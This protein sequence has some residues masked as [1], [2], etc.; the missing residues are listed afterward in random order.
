MDDVREEREQHLFLACLEIDA[1]KRDVYLI[2]ASRGNIELQRRLQRLL[3]AHARSQEMDFTPLAGSRI[4]ELATATV[5]PYRI[6]RTLGQGGMGTVYEAE[7]LTPVRR[8]VALKIVKLGMDTK[9][10]V[11]R[12]TTE[13]QALAAMD[14]PYIA[15]IFDA[16]QTSEGRPFFAMEMVQG[17]P[18]LEYCDTQ[19]LSV[20]SRIELMTLVCEAVQH[21]HQKGVVHRDLKPSNVLVASG[22]PKIIDFGIAKA[23]GLDLPERVTDYT[24]ADQA[25]GTPAYMSPEQAGFGRTDVDTRSDVYSLG[26]LLYELLAGCL[27][28]DPAEVGYPTFL[29]LL[30]TGELKTIRPSLRLAVPSEAVQAASVRSATPVNLRKQIQGDL[31]WIVMKSLEVDRRRRYGTAAALAEDLRRYLRE[32]TVSARPP[33]LSYQLR[34][35]VRR[36]RPQVAAASISVAALLAATTAMAVSA[37]RASR[38]ETIATQEA[39]T[40]RQVSE[41]LVR[42]FTLSS[43]SEAPG[44]PASVKDLLEQGART[45]E[46][47]LKGQPTVQ[48]NLFG[49]LSRVYDQLGRYRESKEL[50][51][52]SL[53]LPHAPG[54]DGELQTAGLLLQLGRAQQRQGD[55]EGA[56]KYYEAALTR[57]LRVLGED[58]LD[59]ARVLNNLGALH[60]QMERYAEGVAAHERA[61]AIQRKVGGSHHTDVGHSLRGL[62]ILEDR[63]GNVQAGL[64]LFRRA[65]EIF[66]KN[67]GPEHIFTA[68]ILQDVAVSLRT[69]KQHE[70]A[71]K[72]LERSLAILK[73][74]HGPNHPDISFT[75]HSLGVVLS[76]QGKPKEAAVFLEDAYRIRMDSMGP[77][78]PRT[79]DVAESLAMVYVD[80][81]SI[82]KALDL[83]RQALRG[84]ELGYGLAHTSTLETRGN[85]AR[86]LVKAKQYGEAM[87]HLRQMADARVPAKLRIDLQDPLFDPVRDL[88]AFRSLESSLISANVK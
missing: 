17:I 24:R 7:Q 10:V 70:E 23:I 58:H 42:L 32:E 35:F 40:S 86:T 36:H 71:R 69:L 9:E 12:F 25:L 75:A 73:H 76:A 83:L 5:G 33:T 78:N 31:D 55:M 68:S 13:R 60:G 47:D 38:A 28:S 54:R 2:E 67:Y 61:L 79:S 49:T 46:T 15:K 37:V 50:A 41:F 14:H 52:K 59:V 82:D 65:Q 4:A 62:A 20:R 88:R 30:A 6:I 21:A 44:Q 56:R 57:R 43:P 66:E 8:R 64:D 39:L 26:V 85:L 18:L 77:L 16:G 74:K 51:E 81:G 29:A 80:L 34:K 63:Q 3:A 48:A 87:P 53:A 72:L 19:K 84:H 27:P 22:A 11:A 1:E 45:V